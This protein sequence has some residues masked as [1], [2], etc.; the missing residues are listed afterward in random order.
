[1][2]YQALDVAVP[3]Q[4]KIQK[5]GEAYPVR[6]RDMALQVK[7]DES[8]NAA[9][10]FLLKIKGFRKKVEEAFGPVVQKA[11]AAWKAESDSC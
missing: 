8:Y 5:E 9:A 6:A 1:M 2:G 4:D 10:E 7:D 11:Y 3:D